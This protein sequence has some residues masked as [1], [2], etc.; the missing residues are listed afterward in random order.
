M[1][2]NNNTSVVTIYTDGACSNNPGKGGTCAILLYNNHQK[3]ISGYLPHTTNNQMELLGAIIGLRALKFSCEVELYTDSIYVKNGMTSWIHN[4]Q[5][6]NF[7]SANK[8][9]IKNVI[10]WKELI[11]L[12]KQH[13]INWNWVKGHNG[14]KYNELADENARLAIQNESPILE[15][16]LNIS[17]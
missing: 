17:Q 12:S 4:W 11:N 9:P 8:K 3:I 10:L 13:K 7:K 14:D 1:S 16:F 5:K 15:E 2:T 6:N